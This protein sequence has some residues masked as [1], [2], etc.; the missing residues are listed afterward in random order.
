MVCGSATL[1]RNITKVKTSTYSICPLFCIH[2]I[3]TLFILEISVRSLQLNLSAKVTM[4]KGLK[5][6]KK[7]TS[8]SV[9]SDFEFA[10]VDS[11]PPRLENYPAGHLLKTLANIM[12]GRHIKD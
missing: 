7:N 4:T 3:D 8:V 12:N 10:G 6:R 5:Q 11:S 2:N 1:A 9:K